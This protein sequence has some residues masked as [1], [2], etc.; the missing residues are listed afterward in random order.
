MSTISAGT[1]TTTALV[2]TADTTGNLVLTPTSGLVTVN[3]TG[4]LTVPV[5]TTAQ[6]PATPAN[7]MLRL[8][9]STNSL[10]VYSS[11]LTAWTTVTA[12]SVAPSTVEYLVVAGGGGGG[13][14]QGGGGGAGGYRTAS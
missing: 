2:S 6:R 12:L 7:G 4:A 8:N 10:E 11:N 14:A 13:A 5:G 1:T 3:A 9:S